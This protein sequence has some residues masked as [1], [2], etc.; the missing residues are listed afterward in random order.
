MDLQASVA[1][2]ILCNDGREDGGRQ[3]VTHATSRGTRAPTPTV[4]RRTAAASVVRRHC[5][6]SEPAQQRAAEAP[7]GAAAPT[8]AQ[9]FLSINGHASS[10]VAWRR[11]KASSQHGAWSQQPSRRKLTVS[12]CRLRHRPRFLVLL[13]TGPRHQAR[14]PLAL[15][16]RT[17]RRTTTL[18]HA[19]CSS[20]RAPNLVLRRDRSPDSAAASGRRAGFRWQTTTAGGLFH[21]KPKNLSHAT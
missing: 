6:A 2:F 12:S 21:S 5:D 13:Q 15:A 7:L 16:P 8:S 20:I 1:V 19:P 11:L 10:A 14:G 4:W 3:G 17:S 9:G 18:L